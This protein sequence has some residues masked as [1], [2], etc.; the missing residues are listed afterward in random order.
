[1]LSPSIENKT[2]TIKLTI[3]VKKVE[4]EPL[5]AVKEEKKFSI[6]IPAYNEEKR[7]KPVL[8]EICSYIQINNLPWNIIVSIDGNDGTEMYVRRVMSEYQFVSYN[9][10]K[11]RSGKGGAIKRA[12]NYRLGDFVI[13]MDSDGA[14]A[15][16]D[17]LDSL[18]L[19][20]KL[21]LTHNSHYLHLLY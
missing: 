16:K 4:D 3:P 8:E 10:G 7:I 9:K 5:P 13:L 19:L 14:I 20:D 12:F 18:P 2:D 1:M 21:V 6:I 17:I 15:F 11:G